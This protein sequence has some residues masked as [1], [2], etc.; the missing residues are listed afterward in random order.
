M[1]A[2]AHRKIERF[3][4]RGFRGCQSFCDLEIIPVKDGRTVAIAIEREDNR[5]TSVTNVAEHLASYV[6]DRFRIDPEKLVWIE[7]YGYPD[8]VNPKRPREYDIVTFERREPER[9]RWSDTVL[10]ANPYGWPGYFQD[11][12]WRPMREEDWNAL[13]LEPRR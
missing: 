2:G 12:V 1:T 6:C 4:Y 3:E 10:R 7:H 11:P 5:G 13:G 8:P 9:I